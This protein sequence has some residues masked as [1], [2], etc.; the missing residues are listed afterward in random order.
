MFQKGNR[1]CH[2]GYEKLK[3]VTACNDKEKLDAF[4]I[5]EFIN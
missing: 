4:Q 1:L 5:E 3:T 2:A